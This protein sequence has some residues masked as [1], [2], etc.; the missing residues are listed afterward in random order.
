M[1]RSRAMQGMQALMLQTLI[2]MFWTS[3]LKV[4]T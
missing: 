2:L 1:M 3:P 4:L